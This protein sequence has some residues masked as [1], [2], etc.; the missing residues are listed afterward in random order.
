MRH[1]SC[2]SDR[3]IALIVVLLLLMLASAMLAGFSAVLMNEQRMQ[4]VERGRSDA[5]YGAH[6]AL[7]KL[8]SDL[9]VLFA[10][11]Y[12]PRAAEVAALSAAQPTLVGVT[13]PTT[14][15]GTGYG[16]TFTPDTNGNPQSTTRSITTGPFQ[17]FTG[18]VTPYTLSVTARTQDG[19][20]VRL[21]RTVQTVGIPIFQFGQF[22]ETNLGFHSGGDFDFGGRVHT[23]GNLFLAAGTTLTMADK[24]TVVGEVVRTHMMNGSSI[25]GNYPGNVRILRTP[26]TYRNLA[27]SEGSVINNIGSALNEPTW[28]NLSIGTYNG[29]IRNGRTGARRLDL[30]LVAEGASP[31]ELIRRP[32]PGDAVT[33]SV[34]GQR[35]FSM[36]SVRILLSDTAADITSLPGVSGTAPIELG[37]NPIPGYTVNGSHPPLAKAHPSVQGNYR[38]PLN[39]TVLGGFLKVEV[40][41]SEGVWQDVTLEIL[42]LGF[43]GRNLNSST[44]PEPNR[45]AVIRFQRLGDHL[46]GCASGGTTNPYDYW[47]M[48]IYDTREAK[49]REDEPTGNTNVY[50]GGVMHY[51]ELDVRNLSRWFAGTIGST[52]NRALATTGYTVYF[53]DRRGNRDAAGRE[54]GE[55][56][57]EDFVNP[58]SSS[59]TPNGALD[60]GEDVNGNGTLETYGSIA[61]GLAVTW[62]SPLTSSVRPWT[63]VAPAIAQV[64]PPRFFRRALKLTNGQ[65]GNIIAPG[66]TVASEN[67][68]YVKGDYNARNGFGTNR[69]SCAVIADAVTLLSNNWNDRISFTYPHNAGSRPATNTWYRFAVLAGKGVPFPRPSAG[70]PPV[71]FGTDGGVHNFLRYLESWSGDTVYYRGSL[72]SLY[73]SRQG[74]GVFKDGNNTYDF[75]SDR[76]FRFDIDFLN[77]NLLPPRTPMFRDVN[78]LGFTQVLSAPR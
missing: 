56:G 64:N 71:N 74:L 9:G 35:F 33:S 1:S 39:T 55:Y 52:G 21:Q 22:S 76:D 77:M 10:R 27:T 8:T 34:F 67:P 72:A 26:G 49:R 2:S 44:C 47:P 51:I 30:P 43:A 29:N 15:E 68:V 31:I 61:G 41:V 45:D 28:T 69:V 42:N 48:T 14:T 78:V 46:P 16:I 73:Y 58:A 60:Q 20:E 38:V 75:P 4:T 18:L 40:Q 53:S 50:L 12:N 6:G 17:G 19:G 70:T 23:N 66:L 62:T 25:S 32:Q 59:G 5:F 37:N 54:T 24:V 13:Y 63:A 11:T 7:E 36:A 57:F 3:G 65:E